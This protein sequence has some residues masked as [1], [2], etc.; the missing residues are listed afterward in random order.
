MK[1]NGYYYVLSE[2]TFTKIGTNINPLFIKF[3]KNEKLSK[4]QNI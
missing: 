3:Y 2:P 4:L 1:E